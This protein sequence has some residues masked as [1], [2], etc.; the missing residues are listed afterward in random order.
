MKAKSSRFSS[1]LAF[2]GLEFVR[3]EWRI[4]P[5]GKEDEAK[6]NSLLILMENESEPVTF[7]PSEPIAVE[8]PGKRGRR[9]SK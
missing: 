9:G 4:V 1:I 8:P 3:Y 6:R 5:P 7:S 2:G